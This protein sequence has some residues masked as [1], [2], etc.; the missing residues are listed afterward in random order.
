MITSNDEF[1]ESR[2]Q[3]DFKG[4]YTPDEE[5]WWMKRQSEQALEQSAAYSKEIRSG[6]PADLALQRVIEGQKRFIQGV[7]K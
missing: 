5:A 7:I 2:R 3:R 4:P 6:F 1:L